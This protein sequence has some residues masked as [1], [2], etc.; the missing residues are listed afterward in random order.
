VA[1]TRN[2]ARKPQERRY[3]GFDDDD[4]EFLSSDGEVDTSSAKGKAKA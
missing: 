3:A 1:T 2:E 4:D